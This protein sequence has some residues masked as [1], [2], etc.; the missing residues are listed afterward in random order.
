ML[1]LDG[2]DSQI[3]AD[4][5]AFTVTRPINKFRRGDKEAGEE[6]RANGANPTAGLHFYSVALIKNLIERRAAQRDITRDRRERGAFVLTSRM[7]AEADSQFRFIFA[8][9]HAC[10]R[11]SAREKGGG[12]GE[13]ALAAFIFTCDA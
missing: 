4:K 8:Q 6:S 10:R 1:S 5:R 9:S 7:T 2:V 11:V 3:I 12:R 13:T